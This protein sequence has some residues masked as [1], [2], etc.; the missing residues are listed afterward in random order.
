MSRT[1]LL[2]VASAAL[3]LPVVATRAAAPGSAMIGAVPVSRPGHAESL[4]AGAAGP[5]IQRGIGMPQAV[6]QLHTL[7]NI[8]E[9]C[10]RLQGEFTNAAGAPYR[11]EG[12]LRDR[13]AARAKYVDANA[14][15]SPPSVADG[16]ILNDVIRVPNAAC[17]S[18]QAVL[19]VWR[20]R[21]DPARIALDGQ[22]RMRFYLKDGDVTSQSGEKAHAVSLYTATLEVSGSCG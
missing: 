14:L 7:R 1:I 6:G 15:K 5:E 16:W 17:P 4:T 11:F 19:S 3:L 10:V 21:V 12:V 13:C 9:A 20:H 22:G 8:P 2:L 18:Q